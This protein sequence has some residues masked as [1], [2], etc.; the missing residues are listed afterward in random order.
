MVAG[1]RETVCPRE[2]ELRQRALLGIQ[3]EHQRSK[4][5]QR[6]ARPQAMAVARSLLCAG[7]LLVAF[8]AIAHAQLDRTRLPAKL[9]ISQNIA[10]LPF[11]ALKGSVCG[12]YANVSMFLGV[13]YAKAKRFAA[14]QVWSKNYPVPYLT[15]NQQ[16]N[17]CAQRRKNYYDLFDEVRPPPPAASSPP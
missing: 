15:A 1:V 7:V 2:R 6:G 12:A 9:L 16:P 13:P 10:N 8:V 11:G 4:A 17:P 14:P 3:Q 5:S